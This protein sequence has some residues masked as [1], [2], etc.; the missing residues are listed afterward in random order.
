MSCLMEDWKY[1][2]I[3]GNETALTEFLILGFSSLQDLQLLLFFIFLIAYICT[4]VGNIS[5]ITIACLDPQLHTPMYF[6][7][8]NLSFLDICYSSVTVPKMLEN[9]LATKKTISL[10]GCIA[11]V[12]FFIFM[13][14]TEIFLLSAMAY[15]RY[16]AICNPLRYSTVISH[17]VCVQMVVGAWVS[18]FL[19]SLVN[20]L[21]LIGLHF[22]GSSSINHF[23]CELPLL[24]QLSCTSTFS[25]EMVI[26]TFSMTL[27]FAALLLIVASYVRIISTILKISSSEGRQ[28]AFSTCASHL[29]VVLLFCGTAFIRYMRPASGYSDTLDKLVSI[30]Y[31]ILT[32]MLNPIIY[33]LKNKEVKTALRKLALRN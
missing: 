22:C 11:Q 31:G 24:L 25:N 13:V 10:S 7:L 8:G 26:L 30:Q 5:I 17:R 19:D 4:L 18:G 32:P 16:V 21:F 2:E 33:S 12:F 9:L 20:T 28:K 3:N 1:S 23:S 27:G 15:D 14:G 6:F 29:T